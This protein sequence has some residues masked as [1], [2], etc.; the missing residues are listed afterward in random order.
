MMNLL[1]RIFK[2]RKIS[3][4]LATRKN[5][6]TVFAIGNVVLWPQYSSQNIAF[7]SGTP[8]NEL[9][10]DDDLSTRKNRYSSTMSIEY[11]QFFYLLK[12]RTRNRL[13]IILQEHILKKPPK[14]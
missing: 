5:S 4:H 3:P 13:K 6:P 11:P 7:Q 2:I 9:L 12:T 1:D 14:D 10:L 8:S